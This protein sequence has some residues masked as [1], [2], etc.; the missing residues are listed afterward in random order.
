MWRPSTETRKLA[1]SG[2]AEVAGPLGNAGIR[3]AAAGAWMSKSTFRVTEG[4]V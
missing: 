2:T 1:T 3:R 4:S